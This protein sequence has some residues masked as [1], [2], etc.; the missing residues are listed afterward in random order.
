MTFS[1]YFDCFDADDWLDGGTEGR[2]RG[3]V[4]AVIRV[5]GAVWE[6]SMTMGPGDFDEALLEFGL[7]F[8]TRPRRLPRLPRLRLR[9]RLERA[10]PSSSPA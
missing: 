3:G 6:S 4:V 5:G 2:P 9:P 1:R 8:G 7:G 10:K